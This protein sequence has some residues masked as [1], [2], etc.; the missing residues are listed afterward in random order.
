MG[1]SNTPLRP[2]ITPITLILLGDWNPRF[3]D[4][5]QRLV[6]KQATAQKFC[7][8]FI[9]STPRIAFIHSAS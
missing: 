3:D 4:C 7:V 1:K 6:K 8:S 2:A 9:R 5:F